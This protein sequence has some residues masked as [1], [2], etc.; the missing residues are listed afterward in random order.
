MQ[1]AMTF[2]AKTEQRFD[3]QPPEL[4]GIRSEN[5]PKAFARNIYT[6]S[7]QFRQFFLPFG[8]SN[9]SLIIADT[10]LL[11]FIT[12][13][14]K[15]CFD[16]HHHKFDRRNVIL[17]TGNTRHIGNE[18]ASPCKSKNNTSILTCKRTNL[19]PPIQCNVSRPIWR[20][21][22]TQVRTCNDFH[23]QSSIQLSSLV[24][25]VLDRIDF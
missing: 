9:T 8:F 2:P 16:S 3:L 12:E 23:S 19:I 7:L 5:R 22:E 6:S 24:N 14:V 10:A 15:V 11:F 25:T 13:I 20:P 4:L 21:N 17:M 1:K 18:I